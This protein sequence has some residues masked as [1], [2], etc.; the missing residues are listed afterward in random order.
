VDKYDAKEPH[1]LAAKKAIEKGADIGVGSVLSYV[2]TKNGKTIYDKA[3]LEEF[4]KEGDYDADYYINNQVLPAVLKIIQELGYSEED[5]IH[6]GK[7]TG[8]DAWG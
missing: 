7:Q 8:L 1:V 2:I 4:V 6:G 5:L 3:E